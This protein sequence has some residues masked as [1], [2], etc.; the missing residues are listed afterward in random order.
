MHGPATLTTVP[1]GALVIPGRGQGPQ[2]KA[3]EI[4]GL[5]P[6]SP[7]APSEEPRQGVGT[8]GPTPWEAFQ[9]GLG[10]ASRSCQGSPPP[11]L[12]LRRASPP[13]HPIRTSANL[14]SSPPWLASNQGWGRG[15]GVS[16]SP[17]LPTL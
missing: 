14:S 4:Q 10:G 3:L 17:Y 15:P 1:R 7:A 16:L 8:V 6:A 5:E 2:Q 12:S 9:E 11:A 13:C